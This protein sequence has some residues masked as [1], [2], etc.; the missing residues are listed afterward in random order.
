MNI[1]GFGY[2]TMEG[3]LFGFIS[4]QGKT[5]G[6]AKVTLNGESFSVG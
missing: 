6:R 4:R 2:C 3:F 5:M 1:H